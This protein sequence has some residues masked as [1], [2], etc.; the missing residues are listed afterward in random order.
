M[1][2]ES[3]GCTY[4][5][6]LNW[7]RHNQTHELRDTQ[8]LSQ[9]F[10]LSRLVGDTHAKLGENCWWYTILVNESN[11]LDGGMGFETV[12]WQCYEIW[13][14]FLELLGDDYHVEP[15]LYY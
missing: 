2:L 15:I 11:Y 8:N 4:L 12:N 3:V 13:S 5:P 7:C 1:N 6:H 9:F 10:W 14:L